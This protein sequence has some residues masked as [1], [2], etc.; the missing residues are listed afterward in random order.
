[1]PFLV[2]LILVVCGGVA[3]AIQP[4]VNATL[5]SHI[6]PIPAAFVS[7][8]VGT[9]A[10]FLL[11]LWTLR[12]QGVPGEGR[13]LLGAP[14]WAYTGG[15]LGVVMVTAMILGTPALG[16]SG[17]V[18]LFVFAQLT[19]SLA[20]DTFG[21]AGRPALPLHWPQVLGILLVAGGVRLVLWR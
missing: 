6:R 4:S 11:T 12:S 7:F 16:V 19:A 15:L 18:S 21:L 3:A 2:A 14:G 8:A 9:V 13:V 17:T 10:L 20:I 5:A 1:M